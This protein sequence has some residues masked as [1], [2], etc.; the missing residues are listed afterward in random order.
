M[1]SP[2]IALA[3]IQLKNEDLTM[4]DKLIQN[5]ELG[6]GYNRA[7]EELHNRNAGKLDA[8]ISSIGYPTIDKVGKEGS[9]AAWLIIQHAIGQPLFMKKCL[10]LLEE[11]VAENKANPVHL[12]YLTDRIASFEGRPQLY[13]TSFDWDENGEMNPKPFDDLEKVNVRRQMLGLNS[14]EEQVAVMRGRVEEENELA[15]MDFEKRR[16]EFQNWRKKVGW[17]D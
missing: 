12:A 7:M 2:D 9:A 8:I 5:G 11:A 10:N 1:K 16:Q 3:I 13:G 14:L 6:N 17:I 4:R 15:P